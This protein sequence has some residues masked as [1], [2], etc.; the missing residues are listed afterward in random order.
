[1]A[2]A[3]AALPPAW[4][5]T[6]LDEVDTPALLLDLDA[7]EANLAGLHR[8]ARAAGVAVRPHAK[9]HKTPEIARRQLAAG[10]VGLCCQKLSEAEVF[11]AA[12][13]ADIV[14]TNQLVGAAK[15]ARAAQ[16][17]RRIRLAVCVDDPAHVGPL[18]RAAAAAGAALD[19][20]I[21]VD[22]GQGRCGV[23]MPQAALVLAGLVAGHAPALRLRGLH[24][25]HGGAQ[26]LRAPAE[27]A[28]ALRD[29]HRRLAEVAAALAA[30]GVVVHEVTGGGTG[31]WALEAA[32]GLYTEVQPGSY[33]LMDTDYAANVADAGTPPLRQALFGLC[34]VISRQPGRAVL[35]GG[36]KAFAT[37][38]GLPAVEA[39]GWAVTGLSD[40]HAV[41]APASAQAVPLAVGDRVRLRPSHC[42]PTV[43]LHDWLVAVRGG[44]V[45]EAWPVLA[46]GALR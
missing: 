19:V 6:A 44:V 31:S 39:A 34:T 30:Q 43:N 8:R 37:D 40:E 13:I 22:V 1:M 42:D 17:A 36:L 11:A 28:A 2:T 12:G 3:A 32:S 14:V 20:L 23:A 10:A 5:G 33:V 35:D 21:E 29:G 16:L 46:R 4:P 9:A 26:H 45:C 27:R 15:L 25:F 24:A 41:L 18:G 38:K 7:F